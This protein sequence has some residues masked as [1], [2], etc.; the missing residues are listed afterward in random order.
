MKE[1]PA[2]DVTLL[3]SRVGEGDNSAPGKLLELG[4]FLRA[5]KVNR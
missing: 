3:L 5:C 2:H 4:G 1:R